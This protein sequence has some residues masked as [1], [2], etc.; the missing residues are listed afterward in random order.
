MAYVD[1]NGVHVYY[2]DYGTGPPILLSHAFSAGATM[3]DGQVAAFEADYRVVVWDM[4]GHGRSDSPE[5]QAQYSTEETV[6]DMAAVLD[7]CGIGRAV[8]G[9]LSLGGYV[10]LAFY[11]KYRERARA[12]MLFDTGPG[13]RNP[14]ARESWN[15]TAF[16]RAE[17]FE[18]RGLAALGGGGE[19]GG[20]AHRSALGLAKAARGML[21]QFDSRV[22]DSLPAVAA[23][24]LVLVGAKDEA[25]LAATSYMAQKIANAR[26]VVIEDAGHMANLDQPAAFNA[27]VRA[28]LAEIRM[29]D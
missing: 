28:F 6:E 20:G 3:W 1:R 2:E 15:E 26:K 24:T 23:P 18:A 11:L 5:D 21:A 19:A 17:A 4:R 22:I 12:L 13:Y 10:S 8:I 16:A 29:L 25:F 27:A 14:R 7:A 9:G